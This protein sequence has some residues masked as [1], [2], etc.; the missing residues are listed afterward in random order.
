MHLKLQLSR[1]SCLTS[2]DCMMR[3]SVLMRAVVSDLPSASAAVLPICGPLLPEALITGRVITGRVLHRVALVLKDAGQARNCIICSI[4]CQQTV[5]EYADPI[6]CCS[7]RLS[8]L[9]T[10][11][12]V[13]LPH[14]ASMHRSRSHP[15]TTLRVIGVLMHARTK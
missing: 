6:E 4:V 8:Q 10:T 15:C 13:C 14:G 2:T 7:D 12:H 11:D 1:L 3:Y 5:A 9:I